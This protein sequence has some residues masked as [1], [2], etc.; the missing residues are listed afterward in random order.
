MEAAELGYNTTVLIMNDVQDEIEKHPEQFYRNL[1]H[2]QSEVGFGSDKS[3]RAGTFGV[4]NAGNGFQVVSNRHADETS[5]IAVGG[6]LAT[7]LVAVYGPRLH[8]SEPDGQVVLLKALADKLG[9]RVTKKGTPLPRCVNC[10]KPI[11]KSEYLDPAGGPEHIV[12]PV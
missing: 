5:L 9:Y 1:Q 6:N 12:C 10:G 8:H 4:G 2:A 7:E 11:R 3:W